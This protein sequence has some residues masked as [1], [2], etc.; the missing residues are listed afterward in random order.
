M[1]Y[2]GFSKAPHGPTAHGKVQPGITKSGSGG[3]AGKG[4]SSKKS[5]DKMPYAPELS[6]LHSSGKTR[7]TFNAER[8][9]KLAKMK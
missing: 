9:A 8:M 5:L 2:R 6:A 4:S 7:P 1:A 3:K